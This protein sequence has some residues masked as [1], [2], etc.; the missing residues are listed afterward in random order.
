MDTVRVGDDG[1]ATVQVEAIKLIQLLTTNDDV[2][3]K[4]VATDVLKRL[5]GVRSAGSLELASKLMASPNLA[6]GLRNLRVA[7]QMDDAT[8]WWARRKPQAVDSS[9]P[10]GPSPYGVR[11]HRHHL[12]PDVSPARASNDNAAQLARQDA[13]LTIQARARGKSARRDLKQQA[14]HLARE[15]TIRERELRGEERRAARMLPPSDPGMEAERR[16]MARDMLAMT[17]ALEGFAAQVERERKAHR[18]EVAELKR[19]AAKGAAAGGRPQLM[20]EQASSTLFSANLRDEET[21]ARTRVERKR[22][23]RARG[24][25]TRARHVLAATRAA[26]RAAGALAATTA[27]RATQ[28][29]IKP[30]IAVRSAAA[31]L[32]SALPASAP[33]PPPSDQASAAVVIQAHAR[34]RAAQASLQPRQS[35]PPD[36]ASALVQ[37]PA[38]ARHA[39]QATLQ[40]RQPP[41]PDAA[42][43]RDPARASVV[44]QA[45]ARR[46]AAQADFKLRLEVARLILLERMRRLAAEHDATLAAAGELRTADDAAAIPAHQLVTP[47]APKRAEPHAQTAA[48]LPAERALPPTSDGV[49]GSQA[50]LAAEAGLGAEHVEPTAAAPSLAS[51]VDSQLSA[52]SARQTLKRDDAIVAIQASSRGRAARKFVAERNSIGLENDSDG[53]VS[54]RCGPIS[55]DD[56]VLAQDTANIDSH[57]SAMSALQTLKRDDAV[58][59]IQASSRGRAARKFAAERKAIGLNNDVNGGGG[60][61]S[62][63]CGSVSSD[64][65]M[66]AQDSAL[67]LEANGRTLVRRLHKEDNEGDY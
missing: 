45:H 4:E 54:P 52:M 35:P 58:V 20:Q 6:G 40:P 49:H 25:W 53:D 30:P 3:R 14:A 15:R 33:Q 43:P 23:E 5:Q 50:M 59:A 17:R 55:S 16:D 21:A 42:P 24:R 27:R 2:L 67:G 1:I 51:S 29:A 39:D 11:P 13:A 19:L 10:I 57:L 65:F 56:F 47:C 64:D 34:R 37:I 66:P 62:P 32:P 12:M 41:P 48:L 61:V 28:L 63:R 9:A 60:D 18:A 38:H 44:L 36:P 26:S 7:Y 8:T 22:R 46:R 31:P